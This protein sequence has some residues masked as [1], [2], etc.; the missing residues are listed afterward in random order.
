[1]VGSKVSLEM[2]LALFTTLSYSDHLRVVEDMYK[3]FDFE[4]AMEQ[5][6]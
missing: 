2:A 5:S 4:Y 3:E 6:I 1:M